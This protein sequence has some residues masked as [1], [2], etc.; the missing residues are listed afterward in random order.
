MF[1]LAGDW[2]T[3]SEDPKVKDKKLAA[4]IKTHASD[5]YAELLPNLTHPVDKKLAKTRGADGRNM[6]VNKP[7]KGRP[8][9][10]E[11]E[12]SIGME[13][14][15]LPAGKFL[16][17]EGSG[18]VGVILTKPFWLGKYEVTQSQ[19]KKVMDTEPWAKDSSVQMGDKNAASYVNWNDATAFCQ[20]I[21]DTDH[22]NGK[23]P[24][25]DS[26]RLPTEAQWDYACRAGTTTAFS[27]GNNANQLG[28]FGWFIG[29]TAGEQYA[30]K[31]G[32]KKPNPWGLY[33]MHG[34]VWEWCSDWYGEK[35]SGGVDP[36]GP[37]GGSERVNHGGSWGSPPDHCRSA[38]PS[39]YVPSSRNSHLGFRVARSQSAP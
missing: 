16:M 15:E 5:L 8:K 25:G 36:I 14:V 6:V 34:N 24:T 33:D 37:G 23:L 35:L 20:R 38:L 10:G 9:L 29:N 22:K 28:E 3:L 12:N 1:L 39:H 17:G 13:F 30:H 31:V 18:A 19:F 27:F 26:Y 4:G 21:T 7:D 32:V 11:I 2:W